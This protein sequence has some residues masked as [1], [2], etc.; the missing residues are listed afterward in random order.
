MTYEADTGARCDQHVGEVFPPRCINCDLARDV[1]AVDTHARRIGFIPGS[2][3]PL[4]RE[5]PLPCLKCRQIA[6]TN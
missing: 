4:H 5:W 1:R 2:A 3:C 6:E